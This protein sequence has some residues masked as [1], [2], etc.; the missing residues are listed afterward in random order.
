LIFSRIYGHSW[1]TAEV[2]QLFGDEERT[3]T[4]LNILAVLAETQAE[5]GMIPLEAATCIINA[6]RTPLDSAFY[7][8]FRKG[9]ED[10]NHS[11][12]GLIHA[13]KHR[14]PGMM[15]EWFC[16]GAAVQD[17]SD[18]WTAMVL[19]KMRG[20]VQRELSAIEANLLALARRHRE[21]V[22]LGRTHGQAGLPITFGFKAATWASEVRRHRQRISDVA[23]RMDCGQLGGGVGSASAMGKQAFEVQQRVFARLGLRMPTI[24]WSSSR[25]VYAEFG[26]ALSLIAS[27]ADKLGREIYNLQRPEIGEL[28][29]PFIEGTVG[30]ITMPHKQNPEVSEQMGTL[31]RIVRNS[32]ELLSE[33][34][35]HDHERDGRSWKVEWEAIPRLCMSAAKMLDIMR[36]MTEGVVVHEDRMRANLHATGGTVFSE[37]VMLALARRIGK[38]SAH[39]I[40]YNTAI[41]SARAGKVFRTAVVESPEISKHL[42]KAELEALFDPRASVENCVIMVDRVL[43][44]AA[45]GE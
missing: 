1:A 7:G 29:E 37:A 4:W 6:T 32:A 14:C 28:S 19:K 25:D 16:F 30:S 44:E 36:L 12:L 20:I 24:S 23:R 3:Q 18:T 40:V 35:V 15:S 17:V 27:T 2:R 11:L 39:T 5:L 13:L 26:N 31:A 22:M 9:Y 8:T 42:S 34:L 33:S 45:S 10:T 41:E 38:N 21:T 43:A